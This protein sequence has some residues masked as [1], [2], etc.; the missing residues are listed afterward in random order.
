MYFEFLN[1]LKENTIVQMYLHDSKQCI[2]ENSLQLD[3]YFR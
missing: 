1:I 2:E 3:E